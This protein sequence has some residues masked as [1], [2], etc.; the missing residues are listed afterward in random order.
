LL[1][2]FFVGGNPRSVVIDLSGKFLY[3][4]SD[5]TNQISGFSIN[6]VTGT[7]TALSPAAV[8]AQVSGV[9]DLAVA[10]SN[11]FLYVVGTGSRAVEGF[12]IAASG[13]LTPVLR[14]KVRTRGQA[15]SMAI[16]GG[17]SP[18]AF[19][20]K[21]VYAT[22]DNFAF[23]GPGSIQSYAL[24]STG[25]LQAASST[26]V[27]GTPESTTID[28]FNRFI[29]TG[30]RVSEFS[31]SSNSISGFL[32][33]GST[34]SLTKVAGSP[35]L[36]TVAPDSV[37]M[38]PSGRFLFALLG[39]LKTLV[40]YRVSSSGVLSRLSSVSAAGV[41]KL[42][43]DPIGTFLFLSSGSSTTTFRINPASGVLSPTSIA[44]VTGFPIVDPTGKFFYLGGVGTFVINPSSGALG[45][46]S[47]TSPGPRTA[48]DP[49]GR[50]LYDAR[51]DGGFMADVFGF[52]TGASSGKL[53]LIPGSNT[54]LP[55][56]CTF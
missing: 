23:G 29:Y 18:L 37:A 32:L 10:Q 36:T 26:D 16:S 53:T 41:G 52:T 54:R 3:V 8:P 17:A 13:N 43:V 48:F 9:R 20:S 1:H 50:F 5:G 22:A 12:R 27:D 4:G 38:D 19:S 30:N 56:L 45:F 42:A 35:F 33:N 31:G 46:V 40:T 11:A 44:S 14:D 55:L 28:P 6:S 7:L 34:G 51:F 47:N 25:G 21:F 15:I 49:S 39:S 2:S 24:G